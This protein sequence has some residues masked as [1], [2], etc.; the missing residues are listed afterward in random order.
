MPTL[1][2]IP[3]APKVSL[4]QSATQSSATQGKACVQVEIGM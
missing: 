4:T 1:G 3:L 2:K